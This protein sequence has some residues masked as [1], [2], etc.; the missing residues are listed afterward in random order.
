MPRALARIVDHPRCSR[1]RRT[2][3][4]GL[5]LFAGTGFR[6]DGSRDDR[7]AHLH[8]RRPPRYPRAQGRRRHPPPAARDRLLGARALAPTQRR[9]C[10]PRLFPRPRTLSRTLRRP[11]ASL[12]RRARL[13]HPSRYR[14]APPLRVSQNRMDRGPS[15]RALARWRPRRQSQTPANP[16]NHGFSQMSTDNSEL[17]TLAPVLKHSSVT[18]AIIGGFTRFTTRW[19]KAF[20]NLFTG[21]PWPTF[22]PHEDSRLNKKRQSRFIF[23]AERWAS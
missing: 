14:H 21:K 2:P 19:V 15:G 12:S 20:L 7:R 18:E 5:C 10:A 6:F 9:L 4:L 11:A 3:R 23:V 8:A 1:H 16:F 22:L 13:A 17:N